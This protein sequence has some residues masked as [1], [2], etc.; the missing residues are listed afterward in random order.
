MAERVH[1]IP[2]GFD[3]DRLIYP[4]SKGQMEAD[5]VILITHDGN[6]DDE[7]TDRAAELAANMTNRLQTSFELIDIDV[8]RESIS[9]EDLYEYETLY[10]IAHDHILDE[11]QAGNEVFVNIS[12]MPRTTAFAFA[13]AADSIIAEYQSEVEGIRDML[14]TYYV[15][16]EEYLVLEMIDALEDARDLFEDLIEDIRVPS[17]YENICEL[18]EKIEDNG[19]TKGARE[20]NCQLYTE[21]PSS[22]GSNIEEFEETIL[23]F[24]AGRDPIQSTS[25][26]AEKLA[27]AEG[28][29]YDESFRSR[30]QYNVS[31]LEEK[32]Y[33]GRNKVGNRLETKLSTMGRMW[34]KTH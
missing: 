23:N 4:I 33:V 31:K 30:V 13:T 1:F 11:L 18:L 25:V 22:P 10:P 8:E 15:A 14:H 3:F 16:P 27:K 19:V 28:I 29:D 9:I 2:V 7:P 26:L 32:G 24:L 17:Q 21:F 12:S 20:L 34:V 6:A 5:R